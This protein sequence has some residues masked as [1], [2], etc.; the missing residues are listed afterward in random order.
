[1]PVVLSRL[2][3]WADESALSDEKE[4]ET[5]LP[6][7]DNGGIDLKARNYEMDVVKEGRGVDMVFN[8]DMAERFKNGDFSGVVPVILRIT[9]IQG[10]GELLGL[11]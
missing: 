7:E 2:A 5:V 10:P 8:Q 6:I 3:S 11:R 1:M 4:K 9:T